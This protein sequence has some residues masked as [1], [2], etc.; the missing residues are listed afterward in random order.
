MSYLSF[1]RIMYGISQEPQ[2][3]VS[4]QVSNLPSQLMA[5]ASPNSAGTASGVSIENLL[6]K[7]WMILSPKK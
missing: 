6:H 5:A 1:A 3:P 7:A 4:M 2:S